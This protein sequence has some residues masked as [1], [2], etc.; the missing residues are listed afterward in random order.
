[1]GGKLKLDLEILEI[2]FILLILFVTRLCFPSLLRMNIING[3]QIEDSDVED[4]TYNPL[5]RPDTLQ[6][7]SLVHMQIQDEVSDE[8]SLVESTGSDSDDDLRKRPKRTK[9]RVR[10]PPQPVQPQQDKKKKYNIWCTALQASIFII[11]NLN[12]LCFCVKTTEDIEMLL[13]FSL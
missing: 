5:T 13:Y 1:M 11:R 3:L 4:G 10:R 9:L 7:P 12:S 2:I 6:P 8:E